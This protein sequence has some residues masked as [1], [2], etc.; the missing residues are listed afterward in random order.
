MLKITFILLI[1]FLTN[2][3]LIN[4]IKAETPLDVYMNDFYSKS[5]EAT[6]ILKEIENNLKD[7]TRKQVCSRQREAARLGLLANKSLIKAFEMEGAQPPK[8]AIKASKKIWESL[9]IEC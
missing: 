1:F 5:N 3:F 7:G 8:R 4:P 2:L 6:Q 9:L